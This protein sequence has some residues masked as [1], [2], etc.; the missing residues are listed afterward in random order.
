MKSAK[1]M[2][3]CIPAAQFRP[4][5]T[6]KQ[7][8]FLIIEAAIAFVLISLGMIGLMMLSAQGSRASQENYE[9]TEAVNLA[10]QIAAKIRSSGDGVLEWHG[11]NVLD[12]AS[13]TSSDVATIAALTEMKR[14][15]TDRLTDAEIVV[16]L[17]AVGSAPATCVKVPCEV[18][19]DVKWLGATQKPRSYSLS[20]FAGLQ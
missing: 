10:T 16:R 12:T 13:W 19:V 11:V 5:P 15:A 18:Q 9:R 1:R 17:H 2:A 8:G 3:R 6:Q 14:V 20:A 7:G 4:H